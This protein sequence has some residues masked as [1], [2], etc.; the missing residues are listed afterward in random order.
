VEEGYRELRVGRPPIEPP[1]F[2]MAS[3]WD[4]QAMLG[5]L[6]TWSAVRRARALTGRDPLALLAGPLASAWGE[7]VRDVRWPLVVRA[8]RN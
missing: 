4:V 1:E 6:D 8:H 5:Y 2:E 3:Q 7:G